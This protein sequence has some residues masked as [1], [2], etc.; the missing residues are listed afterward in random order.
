MSIS[1]TGNEKER[2]L[3]RRREDENNLSSVDSVDTKPN[4]GLR[5]VKVVIGLIPDA[6]SAGLQFLPEELEF[7]PSSLSYQ[8]GVWTR[9]I[10]CKGSRFGPIPARM[11]SIRTSKLAWK[12]LEHDGHFKGWL[13]TATKPTGHWTNLVRRSDSAVASNTCLVFEN[14][15]LYLEVSLDLE[16]SEELIIS[17]ADVVLEGNSR[18]TNDHNVSRND[19]QTLNDVDNYVTACR[20]S[21]ETPSSHRN[22]PNSHSIHSLP[23][24]LIP[25]SRTEE[26][27]ALR[28][29]NEQATEM[30][31]DGIVDQLSDTLSD[32]GQ[33]DK[34]YKCNQCPKV[35]NWKSNL[36]RHQVSHDNS[37]R[38]VCE[39]CKRVFTD[40]SNLQRHI[41]SQHIG[42]RCHACI[43]CGKTFATSSGLKQ[44]T[45][46]HSSIKPFRCEVCFKAYTQFSNLCRHKRMHANCRMKIKC[47]KCSQAFST[48]TSLSKHK[49]YCDVTVPTSTQNSPIYSRLSEGSCTSQNLDGNNCSES[50]NLMPQANQILFY[51]RLPFYAPSLYG[52]PLLSCGSLPG[53]RPFLPDPTI[54]TSNKN[55]PF[56]PSFSPGRLSDPSNHLSKIQNSI[57]FQKGERIRSEPSEFDISEEMTSDRELDDIFSTEDEYISGEENIK[58]PLFTQKYSVRDLLF[59]PNRKSPTSKAPS[60]GKDSMISKTKPSTTSATEKSSDLSYSTVALKREQ[61]NAT[62]DKEEKPLRD[63]PLDLRV[64]KKKS[65]PDEEEPK[66]AIQKNTFLESQKNN[67]RSTTGLQDLSQTS[68][69]VAYPRPVHPLF[70]G[71]MNGLQQKH[72]FLPCPS[73]LPTPFFQRPSSISH[74][75]F[76]T[77]V[78]SF[79]FWRSHFDKMENPMGEMLSQQLNKAKDRYSCKFCGKVF[80]R[81]A[82]LTRHLRTHTGEQPYKCKYCERSFSISS[83][84]QRH[85]RNIHNKEKP[86]NCPLCDRSFGQQT[87]LDRHLKKHETEGTKF[88]EDSPKI[89]EDNEGPF[90]EIRNFVGK[91]TDVNISDNKD[92]A[93][94]LEIDRI[95]LMDFVGG[96]IPEES[97]G[98]EFHL[99]NTADH[100]LSESR[101]PVCSSKSNMPLSFLPGDVNNQDILGNNQEDTVKNHDSG[102][103]SQ[104]NIVPSTLNGSFQSSVF[105]K[106]GFFKDNTNLASSLHEEPP[107]HREFLQPDLSL[108]NKAKDITFRQVSNSLMSKENSC[109]VGIL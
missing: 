74:P 92:L 103:D 55:I 80:P 39:N 75:M 6:D 98:E 34:E 29:S 17:S 81:S 33:G 93:E 27:T 54:L 63:E 61:I 22:K 68:F 10:I 18:L 35:F 7:R 105:L 26:G 23:P 32:L 94:Q 60:V 28:L 12:V 15:Q 52:Y 102:T 73:R 90:D 19:G 109:S 4:S 42:A 41:R 16:E 58:T 9:S 21:N 106:G 43:E 47:H 71:N 56:H 53:P 2:G 14:G 44:H 30:S 46:I 13:N 24:P 88:L 5:S 108:Q 11:E 82:N 49:R 64:Y 77:S 8:I 50:L 3:R 107:I 40:P 91:V 101:K 59:S 70:L 96:V 31:D 1:I 51:P 83:N 62:Q 100:S 79:D 89:D 87:N 86:F 104:Q 36:I 37:R 99:E 65:F 20:S 76:G 67:I 84:L 72:P 95:E 69:H 48:V 25:I 57:F 45:H 85:V 66:I 38:Y 97:K 78:S